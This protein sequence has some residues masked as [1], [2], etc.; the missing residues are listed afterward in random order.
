MVMLDSDIFNPPIQDNPYNLFRCRHKM[1]LDQ[2]RFGVIADGAT[3]N[4][5]S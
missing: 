2:V 4:W 5:P 1:M 3:G